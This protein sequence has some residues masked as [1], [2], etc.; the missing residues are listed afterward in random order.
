M[1]KS[2]STLQKT[3]AVTG[4][5]LCIIACLVMRLIPALLV[6]ILAYVLTTWVHT[7]LHHTRL[8]PKLQTIA[9]GAIMVIGTLLVIA[10]ISGVVA[11]FT[12]GKSVTG[13]VDK[14]SDTLTELRHFLPASVSSYI[15]DSFVEIKQMG[16]DALKEHANTLATRGTEFVH[17]VIL[18]IV[19]AIVGLMLSLS[20]HHALAGLSAS[21]TEG[22]FEGE[23]MHLWRSITTSFKQIAWAQAKIAFINA[24][25]TGI[26]LIGILPLFGWHVP[27][28][29]MLVVATFVF[30][31][32]PVIGNLIS[33]TLIVIL[34]LS[35]AFPA[36]IAALVFLL[37]V[38]KLE[39]FLN[40]RIQ[41]DQIGVKSWELLLVLF[42]FETLFGPAGMVAAPIIYSVVKKELKRADW[43]A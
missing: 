26:F 43:I 15:P 34:A 16:A 25:L 24:V 7:R 28:S 35:A 17:H 3:S 13:M 29:K 22:V 2:V 31:L 39:Y 19:A 40:S 36:G 41:G 38:H 8:G 1:I 5:A 42:I 9:T 10:A 6:G 30:G 32:L 37:V 18:V 20:Q 4:F 27:Y 12:S 33:N 23:W 11:G 14:L 21:R